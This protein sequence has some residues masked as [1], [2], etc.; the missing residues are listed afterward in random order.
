MRNGRP[1]TAFDVVLNLHSQQLCEVDQYR[2]CKAMILGLL[3]YVMQ[4]G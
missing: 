4:H 1:G 3:E 2:L